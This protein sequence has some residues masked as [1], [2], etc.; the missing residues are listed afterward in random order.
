[1]C[2]CMCVCVCVCLEPIPYTMASGAFG[3]GLQPQVISDPTCSG[4]EHSL[5]D[6]IYATYGSDFVPTGFFPNPFS[7]VEWSRE[8][9]AGVLCFDGKFAIIHLYVIKKGVVFFMNQ[10]VKM[11]MSG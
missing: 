3:D 2:V 7:W 1:M 5:T 9:T 4:Y 6:C 11:V 8:Y 10:T